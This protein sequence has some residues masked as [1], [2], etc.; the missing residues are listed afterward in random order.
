MSGTRTYELDQTIMP[1][2]QGHKWRAMDN[3]LFLHTR[4]GLLA[5]RDDFTTPEFYEMLVQL[6][7]LAYWMNYGRMTEAIIK[8]VESLGNKF[9]ETYKALMDPRHWVFK[10]HAL[11]AHFHRIMGAFGS[12]IHYDS[13]PLEFFLGEMTRMASTRCNQMVQL[14]LNY[15]LK[16]HSNIDNYRPYFGQ[17]TKNFLKSQGLDGM[18]APRLAIY[19][20]TGTRKSDSGVCGEDELEELRGTDGLVQYAGEILQGNVR[21]VLKIRFGAQCLTS[22]KFG[23]RGQTNDSFVQIDGTHFGA[24]RCLYK[25]TVPS[26]PEPLFACRLQLYEPVRLDGTDGLPIRFPVNQCPRKATDRFRTFHLAPELFVQKAIVCDFNFA[27]DSAG[28]FAPH[29]MYSI[30]PSPYLPR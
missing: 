16:F 7:D 20:I 27:R 25:L 24:I 2:V 8:N 1:L 13:F 21:R 11:F 3:Y 10:F 14:V 4:V 12:A 22:T 17:K 5:A 9:A 18:D 6:A 28:I 30:F 23:H 19:T 15:L 29:K 26:S